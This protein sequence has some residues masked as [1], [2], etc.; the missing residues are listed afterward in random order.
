M[1]TMF[2]QRQVFM[3][4]EFTGSNRVAVLIGPINLHIKRL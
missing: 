4:E 1:I 2:V 3:Q